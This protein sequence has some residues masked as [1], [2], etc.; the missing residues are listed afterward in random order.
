[1]LKAAR[2]HELIYLLFHG[3]G[4]RPQS[5]GSL[6]PLAGPSSSVMWIESS[7]SS[8]TIRCDPSPTP[9]SPT[10]IDGDNHS[11]GADD[12]SLAPCSR[13]SVA[14]YRGV[15]CGAGG[16]S[17]R[18]ASSVEAFNALF[19]S[20]SQMGALVALWSSDCPYGRIK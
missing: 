11:V 18:Q 6:E 8:G 3:Q 1:M 20:S 4:Y 9:P 19:A 14:R 2:S 15:L 16:I 5:S 17:Y 13:R 7:E 12:S 10:W